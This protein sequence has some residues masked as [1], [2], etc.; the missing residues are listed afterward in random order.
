[1]VFTL[2]ARGYILEIVE[3]INLNKY[4]LFPNDLYYV[5]DC[6]KDTS[7]NL[8]EFSQF[9]EDRSNI[10]IGYLLWGKGYLEEN[11]VDIIYSNRIMNEIS[12]QMYKGKW[13]DDKSEPQVILG[14]YWKKKYKL[15]E[16]ITLKISDGQVINGVIQGFLK[17]N[18]LIV[19]LN[20]A[21]EDMDYSLML[22]TID[23][24]TIITNNSEMIN[25]N[26]SSGN[27]I[28]LIA[29]GE[30]K[31]IIKE[32]SDC[33]V[34]SFNQIRQNSASKMHREMNTSGIYI[35][36]ILLLLLNSF[37]IISSINYNVNK[38]MF[39]VL[40]I[41]GM[42]KQKISAYCMGNIIIDSILAYLV[43]VL[44]EII[45]GSS[46]TDTFYITSYMYATF[47]I[48]ALLVLE[49]VITQFVYTMLIIKRISR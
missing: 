2:F 49:I 41:M 18:S 35:L 21:G 10:K 32:F 19:R 26:T 23:D 43:V 12:Y 25:Y 7:R 37:I 8:T 20:S 29:K 31:D 15:G 44:V 39:K 38:E 11:E 14:Y 4:I 27:S 5:S 17:S 28:S 45:R 1:M 33:P 47:Y 9:I 16:K 24:R 13:F 40:Y 48:T 42:S 22:D 36:L 6:V 3:Q 46:Y 34:T 30:K